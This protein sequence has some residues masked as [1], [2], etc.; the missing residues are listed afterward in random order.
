[1]RSPNASP[2]LSKILI[3]VFVLTSGRWAKVHCAIKE[4]ETHQE[5]Q[6]DLV[7][8]L[9]FSLLALWIMSSSCAVH[10][11]CYVLASHRTDIH[12]GVIQWKIQLD[13]V[14][15]DAETSYGTVSLP[16]WILTRGVSVTHFIFDEYVNVHSFTKFQKNECVW[17][18][19]CESF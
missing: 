2:D 7:M 12:I 9:T 15:H 19:S 5:L 11:L 13:G 16:V 3:Y 8:P 10:S 18:M 1:M 6:D 14:Y 17:V 4:F